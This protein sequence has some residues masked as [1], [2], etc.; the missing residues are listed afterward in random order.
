MKKLITLL[1]GLLP[2]L[3]G[4]EQL[5]EWQQ[6]EAFRLGQL[7]PHECV[8]PYANGKGALADIADQR[9]FESPWYMS[10]NGKWDFKWSQSPGER[11][12]DFYKPDYSTKG[13]DKI[14]VPGNWQTQ[15]YG[16]KL[17]VNTTYEFDSDYFHYKKN[18]PLVPVDS[19]EVGCYRREFTVP[20][21][22]KD[23]R[24]VL[25]L[26]GAS[27]FY[28]IWVNGQQLGYNQDSKTAAEWDITDKLVDGKNTLAIEIY[29][30]SAGSYLECQDMWRLSGIERDVYLYSTPK[31]YVSDYTVTSPLDRENYRDG[32]FGLTVWTEGNL[33]AGSLSYTLYDAD[34]VKVISG[35]ANIEGE[36]KFSEVI[37]DV[38]AWSAENPYLYTLEMLLKDKT[39]K[40][41][42]TLGCNVGFRTSEVKNGQ[43]CLNGKP[44]LIKGVNRHAFTQLGHYVDEATML[45]DIELMKLNNINTVRNCHYPMERR[46]YHLADKHG[47]Y[48]IDEANIESHGYGYGKESLANFIEWLPAHMDRTRRMYA[49]SKNHPAVTFYS[50]GNEAGNGINFEETYKWM[51]A[52]EKNRPIQYERTLD[53]YNSDIYANMYQSIPFIE[54]YCKNEKKKRPY[55]LC[56]YSHA[57]GNSVGGLKDYWEL[58]ERE[59]KAQGG[60]IWDWVDQ[61][62][63]E[64]TPDGTLWYAYGG[65]YGASDIPTD[66]SFNCNGLVNSDRT[67]HPHLAEV[68]AVYRNIK[69]ALVSDSPITIDVHNWYFFTN[70]DQF[71][72]RWKLVTAEGRVLAQGVKT[73]ACEPGENVKI[74]L[75]VTPA[76]YEIA[77]DDEL[78][79]NVDWLTREA[80][81]MVPGGYPIAEEQFAIL[82][83]DLSDNSEPLKLKGK[84]NVYS[85]EGVSFA[86]DPSTGAIVSLLSGGTE[87]L[88]TPITLSLFRPFTENDAH[89]DGTGKVWNMEGLNKV[90]QKLVSSKLKNNVLT[91]DTRIFNRDDRQ[92][93]TATFRYSVRP[94]NRLAVECMFNPDTA[95]IRTIPRLGLTYRTPE[96]LACNVSYVGRGGETYVDR[97]TAGRVGRHNTSPEADFH[98][99]I[100]PQSTGNHTDVRSVDFNG[101]L[102]TVTSDRLFQFS[103]V[104]YSDENIQA[105]KHIKD[106]AGDGM[107]TVHLDAEQTGVGTATCGP[108]ILPKYRLPIEP[109]EFIFF[110]KV[111]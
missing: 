59:P 103:A 22:W 13:W 72:M 75:G 9:F 41:T 26:E 30:W 77:G 7:D 36:L 105:A 42:E 51:K 21:D 89:P 76:S 11:P 107:V 31:T 15:G 65:D 45:R 79:L 16:T 111:K 69:S 94:D 14:S 18:W 101:D 98:N 10:L 62:F 27:S 24:T 38:K 4:A 106:L 99:Y 32:E 49:K 67:P 84:N 12:T 17:Y 57:M 5:P 100:V 88:S 37:K 87:L 6:I 66:G 71:D 109:T 39:G 78:F 33:S 19:N 108:D 91:V 8:V 90:S 54:A 58:F 85:A 50:L 28:Y 83:R 95:V 73:V 56:E 25:C 92:I 70:L 47:L 55:I 64:H 46:W 40:V 34:G 93:G 53:A 52:I 23:R 104:P 20:A 80:T 96:T 110:F 44:V 43:Y 3:A 102:L 2:V 74:D 81:A 63:I 68:K 82:T 48:I 1:F 29:R 35:D 61:S 97:N 60:C 86:I